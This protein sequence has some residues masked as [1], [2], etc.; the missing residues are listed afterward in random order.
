MDR[1]AVH[2]VKLATIGPQRAS[3]QT[4]G[5]GKHVDVVTTTQKT[6][7]NLRAT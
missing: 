6:G 2:R 7:G 1:Y 3:R 5:A 4:I